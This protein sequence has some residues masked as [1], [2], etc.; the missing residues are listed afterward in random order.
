MSIYLSSLYLAPVQY[1]SKLLLQDKIVIEQNENYMKQTYRNRCTILSAN[2]PMA[3]SIPI[4]SSGGKKT[5]VRDIRI[6][7]HGNWRHLHWNALISAYNSTPYFEYYEDDFRVFYEKRYEYLFDL[8]E[9]LREMICSL[10]DIETSN[11]YYSDQYI[12][13]TGQQD[14]DYRYEISPKRDWKETDPHFVA[15]PYYQIFEQKFGFTKNLSIVDLLFNM[16]NESLLIL[17]QSIKKIS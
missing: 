9:G 17:Q 11:I 2:G 3:L 4:E 7:E 10:L 13:E 16:G 1:Y 5:L 12:S 14:K 15:V 8:N 6:A